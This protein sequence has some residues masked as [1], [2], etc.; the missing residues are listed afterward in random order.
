MI[1]KYRGWALQAEYAMRSADNTK[2]LSNPILGPYVI[3]GNGI[4]A[5]LS[6]CFRSF[7]EISGRFSSIDHASELSEFEPKSNIYML[8]LNKYIMKHR[9][10]A[11]LN[12]SYQE[13]TMQDEKIRDFWNIMFEIE[14]GI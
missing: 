13:N 11:Q 8:G 2:F 6:Y 3:T 10:K 14:L 7:W 12:L 5:Q 9:S 4:N 1:A